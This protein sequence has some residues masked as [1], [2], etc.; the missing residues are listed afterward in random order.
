MSHAGRIERSFTGQ[1]AAFEDSRHNRV[2]AADAGWLFDR[3]PRDPDDLVLDVAAGTGHAAR[4]LAPSVRAVVAL[5]ATAAML[6]QGHNAAQQESHGNIIFVRGDARALPFPD[7]SF[8]IVVS[9][10]A[11][12][13]LEDPA[14][15]LQEM[16]RC[17]RPGGRLAVADL[18][19]D[20]Q[21]GTARAQNELER[22]RDPSH[23]RMLSAEELRELIEHARL[24]PADFQSQQVQRPLDPWLA[25][26]QTSASVE[27]RIRARLSEEL[28]GGPATGFQPSIHDG[29]VWFVQTFGSY[30]AHTVD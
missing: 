16:R 14:I 4:T 10:F 19:A 29:R 25:Q 2:F 12:H 22:L 17:V 26:A 9:R 23:T 30:V 27:T 28:D 3:L 18:L 20:R 1:A 21:P 8:D 7:R 6:E 24:R 13:H 15:V 5:D 11:L